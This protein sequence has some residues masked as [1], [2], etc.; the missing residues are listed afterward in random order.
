M[1]LQYCNAVQLLAQCKQTF[2]LL[3]EECKK[4][5]KKEILLLKNN[6][7]AANETKLEKKTLQD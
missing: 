1:W 5:K 3:L 6:E 4:K 7:D 2:R